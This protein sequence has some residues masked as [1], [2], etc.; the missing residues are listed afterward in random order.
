MQ[1]DDYTY[2]LPADAIAQ[3]AIEPRDASRLLIASTHEEIRFRDVASLFEPGDLIVVNRTKVRSARLHATRSDTGGAVEVLVTRRV[4]ELR[5]EA[6]LRP[7]RRLRRGVTLRIGDRTV[8]LLSD[9]SGGI[10]SV[11]IDPSVEIEEFIERHG[12]TPLPP[13]FTGELDDDS[14]YQTMFASDLGSSAA[15]TAALHF[16]P[17]VVESLRSKGVGIAEIT[18]DI[19]LD[20]FRPMGDGSVEDH[21]IHTERI[22]VDAR[23]VQA[24]NACK[25]VGGK[26]IAVGTTVVRAIESAADGDGHVA[27]T[28]GPTSLFITP[29]YR[30]LVV[31]G[32]ITNFHAPR[33][34]LLVLI[35]ALMGDRWRDTYLYALANGFRFL[36]FGDAMYIEVEA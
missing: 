36:S 16:T 32:L 35:S 28:S 30:P 2:D 21:E 19:G 20:T 14:R 26:V 22:T 27:P 33:T 11:S 8:Q 10:A 7:S 5:W 34:T 13:Y 1:V 31:D 12:A 25:D 18:L 9:P 3:R 23:A 29:G 6:M 24:I 15:P 17:A 4:D